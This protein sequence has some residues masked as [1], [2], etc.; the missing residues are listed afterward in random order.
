MG[1]SA[2]VTEVRSPHFL[3]LTNS[4]EKDGRHVAGQLERMRAV[5]HTLLPA[6]NDDNEPPITVFALRDKK[7]FESL[8]PAEY[9]KKGQLTLADISCAGSRTL[10]CC[11]GWIARANIRMRRFITSTRTT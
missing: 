2:P 11:Y 5:F 9:L 10:T 7:S 1:R 8:E 4:S 3:V 6:S